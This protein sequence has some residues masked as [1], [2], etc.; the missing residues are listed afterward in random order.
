MGKY[1]PRRLFTKKLP[2]IWEFISYSSF[3]AR[4]RSHSYI[5][6]STCSSVYCPHSGQ[7]F[8][9]VLSI[10]SI[11]FTKRPPFVTQYKELYT[12]MVQMM[13]KI[14]YSSF[15]ARQRSHSNK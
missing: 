5:Y 8:F 14:I 6:D 4:Q 10:N 15:F 3:F 2:I 9:E 13:Q 11:E 7:T 12:V 1:Y